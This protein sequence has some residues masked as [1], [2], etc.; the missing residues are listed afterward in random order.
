VVA[1]VEPGDVIVMM[2]VAPGQNWTAKRQVESGGLVGN[3]TLQRRPRGAHVSDV[4]VQPSTRQKQL[5]VDFGLSGVTQDGPIELVA[6]L[7]DEQGKE[8]KRFTQTVNVKAAA[9]QRVQ[10]AWPWDNP[11]LWDV[12]QPNLYNLHLATRGA[13]VDDEPVTKFGFREVWVQGRQVFL[14]GTPFRI[15]PTLMNSG[16]AGQGSTRLKEA[17]EW[18]STSASCGLAVP[19][20]AAILTNRPVGMTWPI[21]PASRFRA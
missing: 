14:N 5:V 19:R 6:S 16:G 8:E 11:R 9:S 4:F 13:G 3:V 15:R 2:G 21:A 7:R 17:R 1:T 12:D 20:N 18:A 10:V